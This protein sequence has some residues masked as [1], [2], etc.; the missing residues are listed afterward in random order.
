MRTIL[1]VI[2]EHV[3]PRRD[4]IT[5][6]WV[7]ENQFGIRNDWQ[8]PKLFD[9]FRSNSVL[10]GDRFREFEVTRSAMPS[11]ACCSIFC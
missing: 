5:F 9:S 2:A 7:R 10:L 6:I 1:T 4:F 8:M 11:L 3:V